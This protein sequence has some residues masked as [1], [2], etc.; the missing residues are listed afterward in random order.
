M[1]K[2]HP[3]RG[4]SLWNANY[5]VKKKSQEYLMRS[6]IWKSRLIQ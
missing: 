6:S 4:I 5:L 3:D 1:K 2:A